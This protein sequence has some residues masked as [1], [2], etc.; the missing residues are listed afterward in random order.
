MEQ[1]QEDICETTTHSLN[2]FVLATSIECKTNNVSASSWSWFIRSVENFGVFVIVC[3][4]NVTTIWNESFSESIVYS[5]RYSVRAC[6]VLMWHKSCFNNFLLMSELLM[7][8]YLTSLPDVLF[9]LVLVLND[10]PMYLQ[11]GRK[12]LRKPILPGFRW[13]EHDL[14][15]NHSCYNTSKVSTCLQ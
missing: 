12:I 11:K 15:L 3:F 2:G 4:K 7:I 6:L 1:K 13:S 14:Y 8:L 10:W 5:A 9:F